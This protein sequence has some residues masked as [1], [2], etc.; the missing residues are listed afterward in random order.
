LFVVRLLRDECTVSADSSG[1][2]LHM[3]GYRQ[4][5]AKAPLRETLAAALLLA[6]E[7]RGDTPLVDP[8]CGS[9]TIPIEA[10]LIARRM[11]PG[12]RRRFACLDWPQFPRETFADALADAEARSLPRSAVVIQGSDRDAGAIEAAG[13]NAERAGV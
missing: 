11:A 3:R 10:A 13:A 1:A 5:V 7:W 9:G 6:A 2:L 8:L 4:A 12:A